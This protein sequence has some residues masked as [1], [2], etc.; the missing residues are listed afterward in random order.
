MKKFTLAGLVLTILMGFYSVVRADN[1][2]IVTAGLNYLRSQ[3]DAD[4]GKINGFGGESDWAAIAFSANNI[5]VDDVKNG[6]ISLRDYLLADLPVPDSAATVWERKILAIVAIGEDP[7]NF[8]GVNF[9]ENLENLYS[10]NQIGDPTLVNDDIFGILAL[11]ASGPLGS[12]DILADA[13]DFVISHQYKNGG[14]SWTTDTT[15]PWCGPD[16]N[17]T[18]AAIQALKAAQDR[19]LN[20]PDLETALDMAEEFLLL[21][22]QKENGGFGY[23]SFS[24]ADGSSTAWALMALNVLNLDESPE[25]TKA[26]A[27]LAANQNSGGGFHYQAGFGSDTSTTSHA[28]IAL[29]GQSWILDIFDPEAVSTPTPTSSPTTSPSPTPTPEPTP[30][31]STS[32]TPTPKATPTPTPSPSPSPS[33]TPTPSP[34]V[35]NN[36]SY[37]TSVSEGKTEPT[38][39]ALSHF[40]DSTSG[41]VLGESDMISQLAEPGDTDTSNSTSNPSENQEDQTKNS[42][43]RNILLTIASLGGMVLLVVG[44]RIWEGRK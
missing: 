22:T 4:S 21:T 40:S 1:N 23:D 37:L 2:E 15:C 16:S 6:D 36:Y 20:H 38:L 24:D 12:Q 8:G 3:Q 29:S 11:I 25:A 43:K 18:A 17:D 33:S 31:P 39:S 44:L 41:A 5:E 30:T 28:V 26:A 35:I 10:E 7:S 13:L 19:G 14:F 9:V 27:W 32:P 34:T 42:N